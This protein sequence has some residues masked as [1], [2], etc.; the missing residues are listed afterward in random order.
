MNTKT[1]SY[2]NVEK[3]SNQF[4]PKRGRCID[5]ER[6]FNRI[7]SKKYYHENKDKVHAYRKSEHGKKLK[8]KQD[9]RTYQRHKDKIRE[10]QKEYRQ[11]EEYKK[12]R[13]E[14]QRERIKNDSAYRLNR[15]V[16]GRIYES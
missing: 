9:Q 8:A 12:R 16:R 5:C 15:N 4:R 14:K 11:T 1:C 2:C 10:K 6:E 13:N 7:R 3:S